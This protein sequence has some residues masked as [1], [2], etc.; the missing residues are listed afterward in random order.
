MELRH[1]YSLHELLDYLKLPRST[2]YYHLNNSD[3]EDSSKALKEEILNIYH[4]HNTY[5][6][7]RRI[8]LE[9]R[10]RGW[11]CNK[12]A[13]Q[14]IM[15]QLGIK[16]KTCRKRVKYNSFRGQVGEVAPNLLN[17]EFKADEPNL[18]WA[19]DVTEFKTRGGK[20]Y[21]SPII[22][23]F[24]QEVISQDIST[25]PSFDQ[26]ERMLADALEILEA[27]E[28]K[29]LLFHSDQGW[30]YQM[31]EF[32]DSLHS[33]GITQS[34]SRKATCLDNAIVENF[35]SIVKRE[36]YYSEEA[37]NTPEELAFA[38]EDYIEYYNHRRIKV[39]L[40]GMSPINYRLTHL[41]KG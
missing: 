31:K 24:N 7:Y 15:Q 18:K 32:Q 26:V 21:L 33:R 16:G 27:E 10:N 23:L 36:L 40:G 34:M 30:Q 6:G 25:R 12:K 5:Y 39:G 4:E 35:F 1:R 2:F 22:D 8:H 28:G 13:V 19:T 3:R 41:G 11:K 9:L 14:R 38:L 17:R 37:F 29:S 20:V